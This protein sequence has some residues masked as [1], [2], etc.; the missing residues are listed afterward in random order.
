MAGDNKIITYQ[1]IAGLMTVS[2]TCAVL[3]NALQLF[4]L[5]YFARCKYRYIIVFTKKLTVGLD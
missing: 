3:I 1:L 5:E 2:F 4:W